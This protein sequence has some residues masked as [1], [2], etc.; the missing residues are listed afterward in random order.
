L[1]FSQ[2]SHACW[3]RQSQAPNAEDAETVRLAALQREGG[4]GP[5]E[6]AGVWRSHE[7]GAS[8]VDILWYSPG[9][10]LYDV[11]ERSAVYEN[12]QKL[13]L[14]R[15]RHLRMFVKNNRL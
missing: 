5:G 12:A 4:E 14:G 9:K 1:E 13:R 15:V 2:N 7:L 10:D 8:T 3:D 6:I 11:V